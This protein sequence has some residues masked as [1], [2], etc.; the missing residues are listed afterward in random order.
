M[1]PAPPAPQPQ[2]PPKRRSWPHRRPRPRR[3]RPRWRCRMGPR[4][5]VWWFRNPKAN[6]PGCTPG[7]T[8]MSPKKGT[9]FNRKYIFQPS[10]FR[11]HVSFR[12]CVKAL[13][14]LVDFWDIFKGILQNSLRRKFYMIPLHFGV[15]GI[16]QKAP[17]GKQQLLLISINLKPL[18]PATKKGTQCF[19]GYV[20]SSVGR[21]VLVWFLSILG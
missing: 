19:P 4:Q 5:R 18:E 9:I 1:P 17:P 8:N 20:Q 21:F 6:H 2:W 16:F 15:C 13:W 3:R 7:K 11:E 10:I 14:I 12:E